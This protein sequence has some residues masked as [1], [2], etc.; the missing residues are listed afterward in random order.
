[1]LTG[2]DDVRAVWIADFAGATGMPRVW[3]TLCP[4]SQELP[5]CRRPP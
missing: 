5:I 1:M 3:A 4:L 2:R